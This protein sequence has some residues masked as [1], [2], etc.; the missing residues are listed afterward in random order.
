MLPFDKELKELQEHM[1]RCTGHCDK[2]EILLKTASNTIQSIQSINE[3]S[4]AL[5]N[6][7]NSHQILNPPY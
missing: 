1:D 4:D 5:E 6:S 2:A 7:I 3:T